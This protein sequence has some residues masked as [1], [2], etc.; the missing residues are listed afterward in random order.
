MVYLILEILVCV[1]AVVIIGALAFIV[2]AVVLLAREA[3]VH[4]NGALRRAGKALPHFGA[5]AFSR[6]INA[7]SNPLVRT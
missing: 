4:A 1:L 3:L 7:A 2:C 6:A 5:H